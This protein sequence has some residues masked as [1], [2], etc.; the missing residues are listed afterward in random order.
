MLLCF[1]VFLICIS[2]ERTVGIAYLGKSNRK[3]VHRFHNWIQYFP[4]MWGSISLNISKNI[5]F[6]RNSANEYFPSK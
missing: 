6:Y 2:L 5:K 4:F 3:N 1:A